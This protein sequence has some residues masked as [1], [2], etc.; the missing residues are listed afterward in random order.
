MW[1]DKAKGLKHK[2]K[3]WKGYRLMLKT[4]LRCYLKRNGLSK[5]P[6]AFGLKL[7]A[8]SLTQRVCES[9]MISWR[10]C[11]SYRSHSYPGNFGYNHP[12]PGS[13]RQP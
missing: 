1:I 2:A 6:Y 11:L 10:Q 8:F 12:G 3:S 13:R 7:F 9:R 4:F 5:K